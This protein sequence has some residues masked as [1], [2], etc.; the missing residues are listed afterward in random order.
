MEH[1]GIRVIPNIRWGDER[2]YDFAFEG[3][4]QWGVVAVG[5]LGV[6]KNKDNA[7]YFEK[8]FRAPTLVLLSFL[9]GK[10]D[11]RRGYMEM[12]RVIESET[13][14]CYGKL[15]DGLKGECALRKI[16]IKEYPSDVSK[17]FTV[18]STGPALFKTLPNY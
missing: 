8:G 12:L 5:V 2:T 7:Y 18:N 4:L 15:S 3:L 9:R 10:K 14:L 13:V 17:R 11:A 1:N 6:Y 16:N